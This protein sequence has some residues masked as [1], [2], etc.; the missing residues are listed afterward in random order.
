MG[1]GNGYMVLYLAA[2][3]DCLIIIMFLGEKKFEFV[4]DHLLHHSAFC[5]VHDSA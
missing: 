5:I 2:S 1:H 4:H 3:C